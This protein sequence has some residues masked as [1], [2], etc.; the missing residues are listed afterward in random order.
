MGKVLSALPGWLMA[1]TSYASMFSAYCL[2]GGTKF[3]NV[4]SETVDSCLLPC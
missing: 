4:T 2:V 1:D 3:Q